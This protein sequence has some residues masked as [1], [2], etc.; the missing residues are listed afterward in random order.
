MSENATARR[1][2]TPL[3]ESG[4]VGAIKLVGA[5]IVLAVAPTFGQPPAEPPAASSP[6]ETTA[7]E[8]QTDTRS[9]A[10]PAPRWPDG[11]ISFTGPP[12]EIG[13]WDGR[14]GSTLANNLGEG[15]IDLFEYNLPTNLNIDQ[16]PFQ[17]WARE[18]YYDR[19]ESFTK[20]DPHTRCKPSGGARMFHTPYGF[21]ILDLGDEI[22]F[23]SVGSPHSWRVVYMDGRPHPENP[24]PTW[25]GHSIGHWDGDTLVIDTIGYND[26]FWMT[27]EGLPHT[28][29]LHTTERI[30]RPDFDTLRYE[31]TIDDPGAYTET[32]SGGWLIPWVPGNEPFDYLCQENNLDPQRMVGPQ[33]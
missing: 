29:Q 17:P 19:Q 15:V 31:V 2:G 5:A 30:S 9:T 32:W 18:V 26:K 20:D 13:N 4:D 7:A 23:L 10:R 8:A 22:V 6:A 16:V 11:K 12:G 3:R 21:E 25:F 28:A 1:S 33:D 24:R 27:R 14:P